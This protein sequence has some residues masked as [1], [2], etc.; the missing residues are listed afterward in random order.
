MI[1]GQIKNSG[2]LTFFA[3]QC[4]SLII[5]QAKEGLMFKQNLFINNYLFEIYIIHYCTRIQV[6]TA[7][8]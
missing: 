1:P 7:A 4:V 3:N 6:N 2:T 8:N 5:F